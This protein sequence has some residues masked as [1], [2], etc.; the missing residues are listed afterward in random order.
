YKTI[1]KSTF[2]TTHTRNTPTPRSATPTSNQ[3]HTKCHATRNHTQLD[4]RICSLFMQNRNKCG[5]KETKARTLSRKCLRIWRFWK[6]TQNHFP[7]NV[8]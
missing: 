6:Q 5:I 8:A 4:S 1:E 3:H 7:E 2:H